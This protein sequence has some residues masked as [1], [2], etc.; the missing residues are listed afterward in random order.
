MEGTQRQQFRDFVALAIPTLF[1]F[2]LLS[3]GIA[4]G[5][6]DA[7]PIS[8]ATLAAFFALQT[9]RSRPRP[10]DRRVLKPIA[11]GGLLLL[12]TI[13]AVRFVVVYSGD[14]YLALGLGSVGI[15]FV[16]VIVRWQVLAVIGPKPQGSKTT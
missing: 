16:V 8:V 11:T 12:A 7:S 4:Q 9:Y 5:A 6:T 2:G 10:M 15:A 3:A 14:P 1:L 13:L